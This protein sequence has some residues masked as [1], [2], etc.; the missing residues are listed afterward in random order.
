MANIR[1]PRFCRRGRWDWLHYQV[2]DTFLTDNNQ[3]GSRT[4]SQGSGT[5]GLVY[6]LGDAH[7][8]YTH[9]ATIFEAPTTTELINNPAGKGGF[10]PNLDAQTSLSKEMGIRGQPAGFEY[11]ATL[12]HVGTRNEITPFELPN[13]PG[14]AFFRN[15][16]QSERFWFGNSFIES[17]M[18]WF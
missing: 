6:H 14:R 1:S 12:F 7:Q 15:A 8:L 17:L 9:V 13:S 10:N 4:L 18:E 5:A 16:G 2:K 3:S 11:E